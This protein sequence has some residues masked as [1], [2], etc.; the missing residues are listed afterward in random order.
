MRILAAGREYPAFDRE[1]GGKRIYDTLRI[2][3][4]GGHTVSYFALQPQEDPRYRQVLAQA[5]VF[6]GSGGVTLLARWLGECDFDVALLFFWDVAETVMPLVRVH[7]VT[8]KVIVD[9]IDLHFLRGAREIS[10][11]DNASA[12]SGCFDRRFSDLMRRELNTYAAADQVIVVSEKERAILEDYLGKRPRVSVVRDTQEPFTG[13]IRQDER[14]GILF[15]GNFWHRP[16]RDAIE[17]LMSDIVPRIQA[18]IL[19]SDPINIIGNALDDQIRRL[20]GTSSSV[21]CH[22]WVPDTL[23]FLHCAKLSVAPLRFGAGTKRK[24][25]ESFAAGTP[26]V[27]TPI[28]AEGLEIKHGREVLIADSAAEFTSSIEL[29]ITDRDLRRR[30]SANALKF[31]A[32]HHGRDVVAKQLAH[33]CDV[34]SDPRPPIVL[35]RRLAWQQTIGTR[36]AERALLADT[37]AILREHSGPQHAIEVVNIGDF[38]LLRPRRRDVTVNSIE[39]DAHAVMRAIDRFVETAGADG[40]LLMS[41]AALTLIRERG[42]VRNA[43]RAA[44]LAARGRLHLFAHTI[45]LRAEP[46]PRNSPGGSLFGFPMVAARRPKPSPDA[47][48]LRHRRRRRTPSALVV[49]AYFADRPTNIHD[50]VRQLSRSDSVRVRQRWAAIGGDPPTEEV[51]AV[52]ALVLRQQLGKWQI[53]NELLAGEN[54]DAFDYVIVMDDDIVLPDDFLPLFLDLQHRFK[55]CVAQPARTTNSFADYPMVLRQSGTLARASLFVESGPVVS[56]SR[57]FLRAIYPFNTTSPMGWGYGNVWAKHAAMMDQSMGIVDAVPIDH[58]L[59]PPAAN[60]STV[61]AGMER[62]SLHHRQANIDYDDCMRIEHAFRLGPSGDA[63]CSHD[64]VAPAS[65]TKPRLAQPDA[66][67]VI[68]TYDRVGLLNACLESFASQSISHDRFEIVVVDDG[69][70]DAVGTRAACSRYPNV[71][72]HR[73]N[74]AGRSAAKNFGVCVAR[75]RIVIFF[76]DDDVADPEFVASHLSEHERYSEDGVAVLGFTGVSDRPK[77]TPLLDYIAGTD[78]A[79]FSYRSLAPGQKLDFRYFWEG[80][81]S[82]KRMFLLRN[83]LHDDS[84]EY[85]VDIELG[86]RLQKRGLRIVYSDRP[87][88]FFNRPMTIADLCARSEGKGRALFRLFSLHGKHREILEYCAPDRHRRA[89][90]NGDDRLADLVAEVDRLERGLAECSTDPLLRDELWR[91]YRETSSGYLARGFVCAERAAAIGSA[92]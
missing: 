65:P 71:S 2:L 84:L 12:A 50:V 36:A 63:V 85:Y 46:K 75:G 39:R 87:K 26:A 64:F 4:E 54:H 53:A 3:V 22:G 9:S 69:S 34:A 58:S 18:K 41:D 45:S 61:L 35:P 76:D 79:L 11:G 81:I 78:G 59:R 8:T 48:R 83:E 15:V 55:F 20:A 28:A 86:W 17:F 49:G 52:T 56:F 21:R 6:V 16:N 66:S 1:S 27:A 5:G 13:P 72:L 23:P 32:K 44:E 29:L 62:A 57:Q 19:E 10:A 31:V 73:I 40:L 38:D 24:L 43:L 42:D 33:V 25:I 77:Q 60:Y 14:K 37:H 68:S 80:R 89:F 7:S 74:H 82:C 47:L 30:L 92:A 70:A 67:I 51:A 91:I 90:S 88:S